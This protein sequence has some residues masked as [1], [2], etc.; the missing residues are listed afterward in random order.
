MIGVRTG[1]AVS[2]HEEDLAHP[3][4]RCD[5]RR[6]VVPLDDPLRVERLEVLGGGD[7]G[8]CGDDRGDG[9]KE[10]T[11]SPPRPCVPSARDRRRGRDG[12]GEEGETERHG[13]PAL[14]QRWQE[15]EPR[16]Q[17]AHDAAE[18]V[19]RIRRP[20]PVRVARRQA[21]D[22]HW[23]Q[24]SEDAAERPHPRDDAEGAGQESLRQRQ[25]WIG[26]HEA[27]QCRR[28]RRESGRRPRVHPLG[29]LAPLR[30][31]PVGPRSQYRRHEVHREDR[32]KGVHDRSLE[33]DELPGPHH[34]EGQ[35][36]ESGREQ[37][38]EKEARV[39]RGRCE[40]AGRLTPRPHDRFGGEPSRDGEGASRDDG[41]HSGRHEERGA[42][43]E[44]LDENKR[45]AERPRERPEDVRHVEEAERA[46]RLVAEGGSDAG[47]R[48]RERR[49]HRGAEGEEREDDPGRR[50]EIVAGRPPAGP[51][52]R[53]LQ[54]RP[55]PAE[56]GRHQEAG[57]PDEK[58]RRRVPAQ[59]SRGRPALEAPRD[60]PC[61]PTPQ[62]EPR[63]EDRQH[64]RDHRGGHPESGHGDPQPDHLV[65]QAA[66]PG[67][68]E[69]RE[70]PAQRLTSAPVV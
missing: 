2:V 18:S 57:Y 12:E 50:G 22:H 9:S 30:P 37:E 19:H 4:A 47:H 11:G 32:R 65:D 15:N 60:A 67:Q 25:A 40:L 10:E 62:G 63:H 23:R 55:P 28:T 70:E 45:R 66:E 38:R 59:E 27:E 41:V 52:P 58:L 61:T 20:S 29:P 48:E 54:D 39:R 53:R 6:R 21:V 3:L 56:Q 33:R 35:R 68:K 13:R 7:D 42:E 24:K 16:K 46:T 44:K 64:D 8:N 36:E 1:D 26:G 17:R 49:S 34:L 5:H 43:A 51:R 69:E 31:C 14:A